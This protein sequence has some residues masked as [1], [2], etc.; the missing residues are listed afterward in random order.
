MEFVEAPP[1]TKLL[2]KYVDDE[3]YRLLQLSLAEHPEMGRV[4]RSGC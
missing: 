3:G 4:I 1:F 2:G